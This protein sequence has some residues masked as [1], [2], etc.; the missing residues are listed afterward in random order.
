METV[1]LT[2]DGRDITVAKGKTVLEAAL[3]NGISIPFYCY[4]PGIGVEGSCRV[5]IV[6]IEKMPKLQTACST[7]VAEGMVVRTDTAVTES[8]GYD[9][10]GNRITT[11]NSE[12]TSMVGSYD[13]QDRLV[14]LGTATYAY[15]AAG[16]LTGKTS[17]GQT[18]TYTYNYNL[19]LAESMTGPNPN[20]TITARYDDPLDLV[21]LE[22]AR[23]L[24]HALPTLL[25]ELG[26]HHVHTAFGAGDGIPFADAAASAGHNDCLA[27]KI[28]GQLLTRKL[29][30]M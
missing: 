4:H 5:C 20:S 18:T 29:T 8:Y 3:E 26:D 15:T 16:E 1:S 19:G 30:W 6:K 12:G 10:N 21:W 14:S 25:I 24:G 17:G 7:A 13:A 22:T 9:A 28:H 27:G 2:I 23:R 11:T